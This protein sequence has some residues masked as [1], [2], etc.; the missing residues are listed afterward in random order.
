MAF[1]RISYYMVSATYILLEWYFGEKYHLK[2]HFGSPSL[3]GTA[4]DHKG[5][6]GHASPPS[7]LRTG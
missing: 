3:K 7:P 4:G 2:D 1:L 5:P 6:P